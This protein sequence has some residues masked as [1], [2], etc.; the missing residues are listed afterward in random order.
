MKVLLALFEENERKLLELDDNIKEKFI[1]E[2]VD[3][4]TEDQK[5]VARKPERVIEEILSLINVEE[6]SKEIGDKAMKYSQLFGLKMATKWKQSGR[7]RNRL[8][9]S[10]ITWLEQVIFNNN[11]SLRK[12]STSTNQIEP[13]VSRPVGRP[14]VSFNEAS[15]KTKRRRVAALSN[16]RTAD[17]LQFSANVVLGNNQSQASVNSI[18]I[19]EPSSG[20]RFSCMSAI[21]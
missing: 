3:E 9:H 18:V 12:K 2:E 20:R 19:Y 6:V 15:M 14:R 4:E 7:S 8:F 5:C 16:K 1:M 10:E 17:Q 21:E 11:T 13:S